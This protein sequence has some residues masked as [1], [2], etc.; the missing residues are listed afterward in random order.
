MKDAMIELNNNELLPRQ[1]SQRGTLN[2]DRINMLSVNSAWKRKFNQK[3]TQQ[4][5]VALISANQT[6]GEEEFAQNKPTRQF[7]AIVKSSSA[8]LLYVSFTV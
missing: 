7:R 3:H 6:F 5:K 2:F 1:D 8:E 4:V